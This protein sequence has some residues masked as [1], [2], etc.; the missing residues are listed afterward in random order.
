MLSLR[1]GNDF[2]FTCKQNSFRQERLCTWPHFESEGFWKSEVAYFLVKEVLG[3][4][5]SVLNGKV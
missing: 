3:H 2:S 1:C 4:P 5:F